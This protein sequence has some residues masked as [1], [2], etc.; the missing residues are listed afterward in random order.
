MP[1]PP[2]LHAPSGLAIADKVCVSALVRERKVQESERTKT[3]RFFID[4]LHLFSP[5]TPPQVILA[6]LDIAGAG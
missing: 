3:D 6:V 1:P 2:T 4:H 5:P